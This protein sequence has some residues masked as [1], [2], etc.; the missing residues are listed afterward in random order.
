MQATG[1]TATTV[2]GAAPFT[3]CVPGPAASKGPTDPPDRSTG[4]RARGFSGTAGFR[5]G[6]VPEGIAAVRALGRLRVRTAAAQG[7]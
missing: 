3:G 6:S 4:E 5:H 1:R 2:A 7:D